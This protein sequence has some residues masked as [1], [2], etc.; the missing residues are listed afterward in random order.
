MRYGMPTPEAY[1]SQWLVRDLRFKSERVFKAYSSLFMRHLC[2]PSSNREDYFN[3]G[4]P[5]EGLN[6]HNVL[7]RIGIMALI[8]R[9]VQVIIL[10]KQLGASQGI[11]E[12]ERENGLWSMPEV[13]E[14][15]LADELVKLGILSE[16]GK[17]SSREGSVDSVKE[18]SVSKDSVKEEESV[19]K[20]ID[21][22]R[23]SNGNV[24]DESHYNEE[25]ASTTEDKM[26]VDT[27]RESKE[28][29]KFEEKMEVDMASELR[30][31]A[32]SD[33]ATAPGLIKKEASPGSIH[34]GRQT[35]VDRIVPHFKFNITDGG[36]TELHV[37]TR[38]TFR[39]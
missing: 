38:Q 12:F 7:A 2:E 8:R 27:T 21:D 1:K 37:C 10:F 36:F 3:D 18:G 33:A 19:S 6:R 32:E 25:E 4:V 35:N 24:N 34:E 29:V 26:E 14:K 15:Q 5:R 20:E 23:T 13:R 28:K 39:V 17:K 11:Q 30:E 16:D 22:I 31:R 9:K